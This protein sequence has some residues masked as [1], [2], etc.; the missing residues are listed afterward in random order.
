MSKIDQTYPVRTFFSKRTQSDSKKYSVYLQGD[1]TIIWGC[2]ITVFLVSLLFFSFLFIRFPLIHDGDSYYHLSVAK[3][4]ARDG[5]VD[6]LDWA[7]Y[8]VMNSA[9]G[10]KE[11]LFHLLLV[12]FVKWFPSDTGGKLALALLNALT[13]AAIAYLSCRA[14]GKWGIF[15]PAWIF[16]TSAAFTL[17]M[18]RLRPEILSLLILL[19]ATWAASRS[20]YRWLLIS[21]ALYALSYTAFHVLIGL[22]FGWFVICGWIDQRWEWRIPFY[23]ILGSAVGLLIHPHFPSNLSIWVIQNIDFFILKNQIGVGNEIQ[24]ASIATLFSLNFGWLLG[25]VIFWRST[26]KSPDSSKLIGPENCFLINALA[27]SVLYLLMQRFSIYCI[28]FVTLAVLFWIKRRQSEIGN[29]TYLPWHGRLPFMLTFCLCLCTSIISS[30]Y[31]YVNLSDH[32]VFNTAHRRDWQALGRVIPENARVAAPWD[33]AEIFVWAA[34]QARYIN[35]LDP[36]FMVKAH[37]EL[38]SIQR[39]IWNGTEPDVPTAVK[40]HLDS[41]YIA[42]PFRKHFQL[43]KRLAT[44]PRA[45]LLYRG[46]TAVFGINPKANYQ[47]ITDWQMVLN[48]GGRAPKSEPVDFNRVGATGGTYSQDRVYDGYVKIENRDGSG[49]CVDMA[50]VETVQ[51]SVRVEYE[52]AAYGG[53]SFRLNNHLV[54]SNAVPGKATLGEGVRFQLDLDAGHHTFGVRTCSFEGQIGFFLLER[55]RSRAGH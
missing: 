42:F 14:I 11:F 47:F 38:H 41:D 31:V 44:D 15:I 34:P 27:F 26:Q 52:L 30:W 2:T 40:L 8:S 50:H 48:S 53:F 4:Y 19:C 49:N 35:L 43:Y 28:P 24:P 20:K 16:G 51:E 25:L 3:L 22:S 33:A 29:W 32:G 12:P 45:R 21:S 23:T 9:F 54:L 5:F 6:Q 1:G 55:N 39:N 18:S 46:Y 7:R 17:R 10:D 37:P 13:A 36:V